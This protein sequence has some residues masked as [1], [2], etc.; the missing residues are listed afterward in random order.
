M[1]KITAKFDIKS[2]I[3][4]FLGAALLITS[5]SFNSSAPED[6][7]KFQVT[8]GEGGIII[9]DTQTGDY[10]MDSKVNYVG[11][12]QWIKGDFKESYKEGI[13]KT[14]K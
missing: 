3:I 9:L 1:E 14:K 4:G 5:L 13:N 8:S 2:V 12:M 10:I 7:G 11:K 6:T